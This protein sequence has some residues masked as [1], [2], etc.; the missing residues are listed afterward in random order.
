MN[1]RR[2]SN[3][4]FVLFPR[5][6]A[7]PPPTHCPRCKARGHFETLP[8]CAPATRRTATKPRAGR[9]PPAGAPVRTVTDGLQI[10]AERSGTTMRITVLG[11]I[12]LANAQE[13]REHVSADLAD[14]A[15]IVVLDLTEV[16]FID[17]S[18]LK[19]LLYAK[20]QDGNRLR[21]IPSPAL[22]RLLEITGLHEHLPIIEAHSHRRHGVSQ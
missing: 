16:S 8:A 3:C 14:D 1:D 9:K 19:A 18:G 4:G 17:S 11:E 2:C 13:F 5:T 21:L 22:L 15:E 6:S 10:S 20:A 12:D 7:S